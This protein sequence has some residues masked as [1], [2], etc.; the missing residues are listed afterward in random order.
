MKVSIGPIP[1]H[2]SRK[3]VM[4]FYD[5]VA[6]SSV[7]IVYV[8]NVT[9]GE[10]SCLQRNER[11]AIARELAS[12]G[13]EVVLSVCSQS[14][15]ADRLIEDSRFVIEA[16]DANVV[17][18]LA[19]KAPFVAG[20]MLECESRQSLNRIVECGATRWVVPPSCK[21]E[22]TRRLSYARGLACEI[23][24]TVL[25]PRQQSQWKCR[26]EQCLYR[27]ASAHGIPGC[28]R[29]IGMDVGPPDWSSDI[30]VLK[31]DGVTVLRID[32]GATQ[33]VEVAQILSDLI[34]GEISASDAYRRYVDSSKPTLSKWHRDAN[35]CVRPAAP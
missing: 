35:D 32:P 23:E 31:A 16:G 13:K 14:H 34:D 2:W 5:A 8:G 3:A 33:T 25:A 30:R 6:L 18:L 21:G 28:D 27:G 24:L 17:A 22:T 19:G 7:D 1:V 15:E 26:G 12:S 20:R 4:T 11:L 9:H 10:R 29:A